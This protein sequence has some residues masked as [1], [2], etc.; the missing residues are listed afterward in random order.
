[1]NSVIRGIG[2]ALPKK[3]ILNTDFPDSLNTSDEWIRQRTGITQRYVASEGETTAS[4]ATEAAKRALQ[5][6]QASIDDVDLIIV[7]T[8][9]GDYTFP[10]T[11]CVVQKNLEIKKGFALDISAACSGFVYALDLADSYIKLGKATC[12]I[13]IGAET[14]SKIVDWNDRSTCVLFGDGAGAVIL[15]GEESELGIQ[16][17]KTYSDGSF[18]EFLQTSGGVSTTATAGHILMHGR[19]VFKFAIEKFAESF[20]E[21]LK[22][23]NL[24]VNDID[25][26]IPHQANYRIIEK[27][28]EISGISAEKVLVTMNKHANT[29]AASIPLALN[30]VRDSVFSKKNV[31]LLSMGAG[32]TWGSALIK[33]KI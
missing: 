13:V 1:M 16:I 18:V 33:F 15:K 26:V 9:S 17:C 25:L 5:H 3:L 11:A 24:S 32:F 31:V 27:F 21:I 19:E 29:S 20:D 2:A 28:I 6:A 12:A 23:S 8:T 30:E 22:I 4:L 7:A 10:S 14:F